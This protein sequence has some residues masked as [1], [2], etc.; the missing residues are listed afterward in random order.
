MLA[1]KP[2]NGVQYKSKIL[3]DYLKKKEFHQGKVLS[4][5]VRKVR[6]SIGDF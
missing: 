2:S 3:N 5:V 6:E 4:I 1:H